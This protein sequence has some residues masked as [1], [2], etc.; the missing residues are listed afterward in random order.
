MVRCAI[1]SRDRR[2]P[3]R[4]EHPLME[5]LKLRTFAITSGYEDGDDCDTLRIDPIFKMA[6]GHAPDSGDPFQVHHDEK[7]ANRIDPQT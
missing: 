1:R 6:V 4:I 5:M 3:D 2:K 7:V